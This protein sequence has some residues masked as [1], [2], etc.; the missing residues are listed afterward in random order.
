ML[1]RKKAPE[2][3]NIA[4]IDF[5]KP[6][7]Y[8]ITEKCHLFF[9]NEVP[10]DTARID[11]HFD[12]GSGLG[13]LGIASFVGGLLFSGTAEKSSI[14]ISNELDALGAFYESNVAHEQAMI[15]VY[16]L[17]EN[18]V[19]ILR[20]IKDAVDNI[21]FHEDEVQEMLNDR[22]QKFRVNMGKVSF[23]AQRKFQEKLLSGTPYGRIVEEDDYDNVS[24]SALKR[25]HKENYLNGLTKVVL[26][27]D[28]AQDE[29]DE[30]IDITGAWATDR[31]QEF[32]TEF[33]N[34][35]GTHEVLKSD[36]IQSAIRIGRILF[37]KTHPDFIDFQVLNTILGDYF[38]S[39]LMSNIREDKGYTYG[40][41][42]MVAELNHSGYFLI[43]TEVAKEVKDATIQEVKYELEK[44]KEE[45]VAAEELELVK[46]YMLGQLLKSADGPYSMIDLYM[47][48]EP[49]DMEMEFYN[50]SIDSIK[51]ITPERIR[52]L[53]AKYLDWNDM[54]VVVAGS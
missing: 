26:V 41:G 44:L 6:H 33:K 23:L 34:E 11:L 22:K 14:Q 18:I 35:T 49:Y 38:G 36:A 29:V 16:A 13:E 42:S 1:N 19:P 3:Q 24:I 50:R 30:I 43:A 5:V 47:G 8:D 10:N 40:I 9:M 25:F 46:N 54:T 7:V 17:K 45:L 31:K 27:G 52:E 21:S 48:L 37:N 15:T 32:A 39:R 51:S 4:N 2:L 12:A 20:I 53:A 28:L